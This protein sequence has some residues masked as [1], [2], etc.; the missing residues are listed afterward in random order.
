MVRDV[1]ENSIEEI[2][3]RQILNRCIAGIKEG[4]TM[5]QKNSNNTSHKSLS[6]SCRECRWY[7]AHRSW[8]EADA[9]DKPCDKFKDL[10][11]YADDME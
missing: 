9:E 2:Y 8:C 3:D 6:K 5:I 7:G 10:E 4:E 11:L 1:A